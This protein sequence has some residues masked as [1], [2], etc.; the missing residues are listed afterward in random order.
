MKNWHN[1]QQNQPNTDYSP[2]QNIT[3]ITAEQPY[4]TN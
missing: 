2:V 1:F 4:N 3:A